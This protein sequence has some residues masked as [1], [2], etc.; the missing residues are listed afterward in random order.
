MKSTDIKIE[1]FSF[2]PEPWDKPSVG[3]FGLEGSGKTRLACSMPHDDGV[4]GLIALDKKSLRT[5]Q[6]EAKKQGVPYVA[7]PKPY[8]SDKDLARLAML[9]DESDYG[10]GKSKNTDLME[11]RQ[12]ELRR[13]Y[14]GVTDRVFEDMDRLVGSS[15]VESVVTDTAAQLYQWLAY[16]HFGRTNQ[17]PALSRDVFNQDMIDFINMTRGKNAL[18]INR[19]KEVWKKVGTNADG[20]EKKEPSGVYEPDGF[21]GIG[22][23][24]TVYVEM[25]N[26]KLGAADRATD[27]ALDKKFR[28]KVYRCQTNALL[29]GMDLGEYGVCGENITWDNLMVAIGFE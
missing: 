8:I 2:Q 29:E 7:N 16:K 26:K 1:G 22:A 19:A 21:K 10:R 6:Q 13:F 4:I 3:A 11:E 9:V 24:L 12:S 15:Q 28:C 17:I 5:F 23:H 14:K 25:I 20:T 27:E 18:F